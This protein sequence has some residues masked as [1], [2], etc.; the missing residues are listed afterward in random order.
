MG[1]LLNIGASATELYRQALSTVSNNIAN[2]NSD[3][4]SR[5]EI[6]AQE[7]HPNLQGVSYLG[8]GANSKGVARAFDE[9]AT[10]NIRI[11]NSKLNEQEPLIRYTDRLVDLLGS[12]EGSLTTAMNGFFSATSQLS[13]NPAEES[14]R[15]QFLSSVNFFA[16]RSK[17]IGEELE[18]I[19]NEIINSLHNEFDELNELASSLAL[20]NKELTKTPLAGKQP[21]ALLDQRDFLLLEMSKYSSLDITI[22]SGGRALVK[23]AGSNKSTTFVDENKSYLLNLKVSRVSGGPIA[24]IFDSYGKNLT[25][26]EVINGSVGGKMSFRNSIFEPLRDDL[27]ILVSTVAQSINNIHKEGLTKDGQVGLSL[28]DLTPEYRVANVADSTL[29]SSISAKAPVGNDDVNIQVKWEADKR[30]WLVTDLYTNT[31][32]YVSAKSTTDPSF[33]YEG[34]TV[35][36]LRTLQDR[37]QFFIQPHM[38]DIDNIKVKIINTAQIATADRLQVESNI[39]NSVG[40]EPSLEYDKRAKALNQYAE[41]DTNTV[42]GIRQTKSF[43]TNTIEPALFIPRNANGFTVSIQPPVADSYNLQM[44]T[45]EYNHILGSAALPAGFL[46]GLATSKSLESG[47]SLVNNYLNLQGAA[48]YKDTS[49]TLGS[50]AKSVRLSTGLPIQTNATVAAETLIASTSLKI[51]GTNLDVLTLNA[52]ETL[53]AKLVQDWV[54]VKTGA[55]GVTA[56]ADNTL[57]YSY[58]DF[59]LTRKLS[60]NGQGIVTAA[61][62]VPATLEALAI[63]INAKTGLT[64][65]KASVDKRTDKISITNIDTAAEIG[66]NI[67]LSSD[68]ASNFLGVMNEIYV[69]RVKYTGTNINFEFQNYGAGNGE[70]KDLSRLGLAT[71][72]TS[73]ARMDDDF[74]LYITGSVADVDLRY[75]INKIPELPEVEVENPFSVTFLSANQ[76]Q[77]TDTNT[78][79]ILAKKAYTWP[80][81]VLVNDVKV[82]FEQAPASGDIFTIERNTGAVGD[83]GN[84]NRVLAVKNTGVNGDLIPTQN[85]ISLISDI[86]NKNNLAKMSS[87]ALSVVK[88]DAE[89]LLDNTVGVTLDSE[90]A[91]LIKYQQSYQAAAQII[92]VARDLFETLL[93]TSR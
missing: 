43:K 35:N 62:G 52:G 29:A 81:G 30:R 25:V 51:N 7:N 12:E 21:P 53:S 15:Q 63:L 49:I 38:R 23:L 13:S 11:A 88:N 2:L 65:V 83:N 41:L 76:V 17:A 1:D 37:E 68:S 14:F 27:D 22:D 39:T 61:S 71:T 26:G 69:G 93:A 16:E 82:V 36:V 3:G 34:I 45:S 79:T 18:S 24:V 86:G 66:K 74:L 57:S 9:F 28:F 55:S 48:A 92:K 40:S 31:N 75:D 4:Y 70:P 32:S 46:G 47:T 42:L 64:D 10:S 56:V 50:F 20:V 8:T 87:E 91:D 33:S 85:Y 72:I 5:Q 84:I 59:D 77:I 90:A 58:E 67:V 73:S 44:F 78:N 6:S 19:E 60:I 80:N 89:A 54:N